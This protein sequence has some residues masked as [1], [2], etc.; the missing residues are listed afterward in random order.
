MDIQNTASQ[1]PLC[2]VSILQGKP[3]SLTFLHSQEGRKVA[4]IANRVT[5]NILLFGPSFHSKCTFYSKPTLLKLQI[6]FGQNKVDFLFLEN[7][8]NEENKTFWG[9]WNLIFIYLH[10][11]SFWF[12]A[13]SKPGLH[14]QATPP[15]GVSRQMCAHPWSLFIQFI[16]SVRKKK[17]REMENISSEIKL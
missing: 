4:T 3:V 7:N 2:F 5:A 10:L 1:N 14:S 8:N 12:L 6:T 16:P 13:S 11:Q 15:L 9:I 17:E